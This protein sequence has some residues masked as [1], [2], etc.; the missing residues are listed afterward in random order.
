VP[1]AEQTI[2]STVEAAK[3]FPPEKTWNVPEEPEATDLETIVSELERRLVPFRTTPL[4]VGSRECR[5]F[6]WMMP[7]PAENRHAR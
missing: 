1:G 3:T 2:D 4:E 7:V 6:P 5:T